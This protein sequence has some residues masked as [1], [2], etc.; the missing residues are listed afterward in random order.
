[1]RFGEKGEK[2]KE[3]QRKVMDLGYALPRYGDD[4]DLGGE[5][6]AAVIDCITDLWPDVPVEEYLGD[7]DSPGLDIPDTVVQA[8]MDAPLPEKPDWLFDVTRDHPVKYAY[9]TRRRLSRID[10]ITLHQTAC[11]LSERL[12][13]WYFIRC[14]FGITR[15]GRAIKVNTFDVVIQ[16][17]NWFN[18]RSIAFEISGNFRGAEDLPRTFWKKGGRR[19][20]LTEPQIEAGRNAMAL[21]CRDVESAGG[22]IKY[23]LAHRQ[24]NG[25]KENCPGEAIWKAYGLWAQKQLG[26]ISDVDYVHPKSTNGKPIPKQWDPRSTHE[27]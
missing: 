20:K 11:N 19:A 18:H 5:S 12:S 4:G 1:M 2:V 9:S 7:L 3:L 16:A 27:F 13:R 25:N 10:S 26:L 22:K 14:H 21:C 24:A 6:V 15:G 17:S 8:I 23:V